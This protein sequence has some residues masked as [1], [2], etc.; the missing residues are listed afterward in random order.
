MKLLKHLSL[1]VFLVSWLAMP[2]LN[3]Q[4]QI[5]GK[6]LAP[7]SHIGHDHAEGEHEGEAVYDIL[8]GATVVW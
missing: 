8:P 1:L 5:K 4:N 3:A 7:E 6:V 2:N